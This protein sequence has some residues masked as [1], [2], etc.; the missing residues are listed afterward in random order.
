MHIF[1]GV[2]NVDAKLHITLM[3]QNKIDQDNF[4]AKLT[5]SLRD[6]SNGV[7]VMGWFNLPTKGKIRLHLQ[8]SHQYSKVHK[9]NKEYNLINSPNV[10]FQYINNLSQPLPAPAG[11]PI[12]H[13]HLY[14]RLLQILIEFD[15]GM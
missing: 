9:I 7:P 8:F 11:T 4:L 2:Q 13:H 5:I 1:S 6:I 14:K 3:D 12:D 10:S 15:N